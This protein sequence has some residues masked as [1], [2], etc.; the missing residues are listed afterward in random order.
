[1]ASGKV[2]SLL[3]FQP[4]IP[5]VHIAFHLI[6]HK[7]IA[8]NIVLF[9]FSQGFGPETLYRYREASFKGERTVARKV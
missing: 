9:D 1:M 4:N 5:E 7:Y 8:I 6:Q 3:R 2:I